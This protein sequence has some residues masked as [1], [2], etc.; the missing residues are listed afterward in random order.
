[1]IHGGLQSESQK[2]LDNNL[3]GISLHAQETIENA[4]YV[5][6]ANT[7]DY[8]PTILPLSDLPDLFYAENMRHLAFQVNSDIK[9][10]SYTHLTLPT[11]DLV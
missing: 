7:D 9:A 8:K 10:V 11:S 3:D 5:Y 4:V 1:M 2:F 6:D